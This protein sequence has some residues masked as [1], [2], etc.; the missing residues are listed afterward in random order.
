MNPYIATIAYV[1]GIWL[2]FK[3]DRDIGARTSKALWIP[4]AWLFLNSSRP[5]TLWLSSL[6]IGV[7]GP[8][9]TTAALYV[10]GSPVDRLVYSALVL[11]GFVVLLSGRRRVGSLLQKNIPVVLF[12]SYCLL[13]CV[14][15]DY[16]FV[17]LKHWTKGIGDVVMVLIVLTDSEAEVALKRFL[18]RVGFLVL[19]L[20]VLFIKYYPQIGREYS[21]WTWTPMMC[22]VAV[23]KNGLGTIC[24]IFGLGSVWRFLR[25]YSSDL[26][27]ER[28]RHLIAHSV[29]IL[30]AV[31]LLMEANSMTSLSC[32]VAG[33]SLMVTMK[34][35]KLARRPLVTHMLIAVMI[36]LPI[37]ALFFD[38]GGS[39][40][41]SMGRDPTLTGRV[42]IWQIILKEAGSPMLGTGYESFWLGKRLDKIWTNYMPGL[43]EAHNGYL[44]IYLNLGW[45]GVALLAILI[46]T[47]YLNVVRALRKNPDRDSIKLAYFVIG[48]IYCLSE[49]GFRMMDP[50]WI[51]FL[52]VITAAPECALQEDSPLLEAY[53]PDEFEQLDVVG[54]RADEVPLGHGVAFRAH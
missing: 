38:S 40:V 47:G 44:E 43:Q 18:M 24:L 41:H 4:V 54:V 8:I 9:S 30:T 33:S 11:A 2:L 36:A 15:S 51:L 23:G 42:E 25:A 50:I 16:P 45:I 7:S 26:G 27:K 39:L 28:R 37:I 32:F 52:L 20:S 53:T 19:P 29:L 14:W 48:V 34:F 12:F 22:G 21:V 6:G 3:L 17:T 49:A 10:D 5:V 31:W 1:L 13:S 35:I 46:V